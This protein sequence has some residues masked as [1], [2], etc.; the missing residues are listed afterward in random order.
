MR[1][2]RYWLECKFKPFE[3]DSKQSNAIS[4]HSKPIRMQIRTI[5]MRFEAIKFN[6]EPLYKDL[7]KG[8]A[9]LNHLNKLQCNQL[10]IW[11]IW[12]G[13][14]PVEWKFKPFERDSKQLKANSNNSKGILIIWMQIQAIRKNSNHSNEKLWTIRKEFEAF[15]WKFEPFESDSK[16]S[17]A[18]SNH[19]KGI[20]SIRMRI[21]NFRNGF[22]GF[23]CKF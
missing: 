18:N 16:H 13:F 1:Y 14:K 12:K 6:F 3:R 23:E 2:I 21:Q 8:N 22:K 7:K 17:N 19:L 11:T 4:K 15:E 20:L 5:R 9:N 10:Q